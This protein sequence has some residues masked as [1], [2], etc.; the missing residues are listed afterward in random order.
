MQNLFKEKHKTKGGN[1]IFSKDYK[2][3]AIIYMLVKHLSYKEA[4]KIFLPHQKSEDTKTIRSWKKI[5]QEKGV[6]GFFAMNKNNSVHK[7]KSNNISKTRYDKDALLS[8][9]K[10]ELWNYINHLHLQ[11]DVLEQKEKILL[12][13]NKKK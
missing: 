10:D 3:Y 4:T 5:Y 2:I 7:N 12:D 1:V 8:L 6:S 11:I 9:S 13:N